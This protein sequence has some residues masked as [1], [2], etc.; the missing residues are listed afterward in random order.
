MNLD[1][2]L[3]D[4]KEMIRVREENHRLIEDILVQRLKDEAKMV[5]TQFHIIY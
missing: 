1:Q 2:L 3:I 5:W 4:F